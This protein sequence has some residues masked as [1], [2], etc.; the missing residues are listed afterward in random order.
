MTMIPK[1]FQ[2]KQKK[3]LKDFYWAYADILRGIGINESMYDQRIMA[4]MALKLL[5]DNDFIVFD[6]DYKNNFNLKDKFAKYKAKNTKETFLNIIKDIK[7][8]GT[9]K[10]KYFTQNK[11]LNPNSEDESILY[12][13]DNQRT[14]ELPKY[15][16]EYQ[17][18]ILRW[19]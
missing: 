7:K 14:F 12:Y 8:L 9:T 5:I 6:F 1:D 2:T 11:N 4:F 19:F 15:I 18:I 3:E 16:E 13:L 10:L 17:T